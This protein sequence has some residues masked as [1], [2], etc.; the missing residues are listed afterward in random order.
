MPLK[1]LEMFLHMLTFLFFAL[2][3]W[4]LMH[5]ALL[6]YFTVI[7][8]MILPLV[9]IDFSALFLNMFIKL[10]YKTG[11]FIIS[12]LIVSFFL[13]LALFLCLCVNTLHFFYLFTSFNDY[14]SS[15]G[16]TFFPIHDNI[17]KVIIAP[18]QKIFGYSFIF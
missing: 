14:N 9:F 10:F 7:V 17:A 1:K 8:T 16:S 6:Y 2:V 12:C 5:F 18:L 3:I 11:F 15:T 4:H 13:G